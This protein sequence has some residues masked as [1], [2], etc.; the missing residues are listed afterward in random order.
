M[1]FLFFIVRTIIRAEIRR[2]NQTTLSFG[3]LFWFLSSAVLTGAVDEDEVRPNLDHHIGRVQAGEQSREHGRQVRLA[4]LLAARV[5]RSI[6]QS[7]DF[8][9]DYGWKNET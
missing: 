4:H 7:V 8:D 3:P 2:G 5:D 1:F 6:G 9:A